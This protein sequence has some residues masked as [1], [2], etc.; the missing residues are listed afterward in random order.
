MYEKRRAADATLRS[1]FVVIVLWSKMLV[2][3]FAILTMLFFD[4][5]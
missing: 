2:A 1:V 4:V 5:F 3:F